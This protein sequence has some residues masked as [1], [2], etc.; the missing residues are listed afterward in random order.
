MFLFKAAG[1]FILTAVAEILGC[2]LPLSLATTRLHRLAP[3]AGGAQ[4]GDLRLAAQSAPNRRGPGICGL[5]RR[6]RDC[7]HRLA[8]GRQR[9]SAH[10][11]GYHRFPSNPDGHVYYCFRR[12]DFVDA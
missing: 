12:A 3:G 10:V 2:Y 4:P 9:G 7:G 8:L 5:R 11:M 1:L 6:L